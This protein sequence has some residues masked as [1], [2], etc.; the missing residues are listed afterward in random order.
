METSGEAIFL[1]DVDGIIIFINPEFTRLYGFTSEEVIGK[2]TP[3]ILKS[4]KL[5]PEAYEE[6]WKTLLNKQV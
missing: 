6:F 4:G 2:A 1:A 3:R 5:P